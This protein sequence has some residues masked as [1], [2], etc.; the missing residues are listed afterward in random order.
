MAVQRTP[1]RPDLAARF[2]I[3]RLCQEID[4]GFAG[5]SEKRSLSGLDRSGVAAR[6]KQRGRNFPGK[7]ACCFD[8]W[9]EGY[10]AAAT[11]GDTN[12]DQGI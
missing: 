1:K 10:P 9:Q 7:V 12:A 11:G 6:N 3:R 2:R 8:F 4:D 5:P